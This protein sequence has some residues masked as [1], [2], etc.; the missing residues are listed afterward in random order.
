MAALKTALNKYVQ[1]M[2]ASQGA[3]GGVIDLSET[4]EAK[5]LSFGAL[6]AET[7]ERQDEIFD[8]LLG[9]L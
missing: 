5:P 7:Q 9:R 4:G 1:L 6:L 3:L 8:Q 2:E